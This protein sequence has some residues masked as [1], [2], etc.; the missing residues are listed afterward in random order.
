MSLDSSRTALIVVDMLE[1]F[2]DSAIWPE[3]DLPGRK[4]ELVANINHL[5]ETFRNAG[6]PVF[7]I[8]QEFKADLSDAFPHMRRARK[9]YTISG[10][11]GARLVDGLDVRDS[12]LF[13][14]KKR[15]SAFFNTDL[16]AK[17]EALGTDTLV[18]AGITTSWCIRSTATDAYQHDFKV[19]LC[20]D[21]M[22]GFREDDHIRDLEAMNGYIA[23]THVGDEPGNLL[24]SP[25]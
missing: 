4:Q 20:S 5:L 19:L 9:S 16:K 3:S 17:L 12:D 15:F 2:F 8:K 21:C 10:T 23:R 18:L 24:Q 7:W 1:D 13:V 22:A 25:S 6:V 11:A 14:L